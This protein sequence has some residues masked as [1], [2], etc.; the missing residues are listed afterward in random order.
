MKS[1]KWV[2]LRYFL[3]DDI[4]TTHKA[5]H[6]FSRA[7][8]NNKEMNE[9]VSGVEYPAIELGFDKCLYGLTLYMLGYLLNGI[10]PSLLS[11][12]ERMYRV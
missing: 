2:P 8:L 7:G 5:M 9:H 4:F 3:K 1:Y 6:T 12:C 10:M 11:F